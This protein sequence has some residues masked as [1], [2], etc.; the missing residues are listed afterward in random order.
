MDVHQW[1]YC[2]LDYDGS[3]EDRG[4]SKY[5]VWIVYLYHEERYRQLAS[6][7]R[8]GRIFAYNPFYSAMGYLGTFGWELITVQH[9]VGGAGYGGSG[10]GGVRWDNVVAYFRRPIKPGRRI[11]EPPLV[12]P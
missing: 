5:D 7:G 8:N 6:T 4:G 1:E 9:G 3:K 10:G 11:D 12:L 2:R